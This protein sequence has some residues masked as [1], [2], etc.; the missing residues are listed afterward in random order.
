VSGQYTMMDPTGGRNRKPRYTWQQLEPLYPVHKAL[1][2]MAAKY[3]EKLSKRVRVPYHHIIIM[4]YRVTRPK[5]VDGKERPFFIAASDASR[6][7]RFGIQISLSNGV[8]HSVSGEHG[9]GVAELGSRPGGHPARRHQ[10]RRAGQ[11]QS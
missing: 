3:T 7:T 1:K 11:G 4:S 6:M 10:G 8:S 9:A 2:D 5:S